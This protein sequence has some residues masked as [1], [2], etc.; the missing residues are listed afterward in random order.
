MVT[1][2]HPLRLKLLSQLFELMEII[3]GHGDFHII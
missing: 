1:M 3:A 2:I